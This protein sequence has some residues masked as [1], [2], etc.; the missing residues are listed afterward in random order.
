ML[1]ASGLPY[2]RDYPGS[3]TYVSGLFLLFTQHIPVLN[4]CAPPAGRAA[5][6]HTSE[7]AK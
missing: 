7:R 4:E 2:L 5:Q 1:A 6:N 3:A